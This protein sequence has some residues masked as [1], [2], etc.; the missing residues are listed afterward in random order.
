[1]GSSSIVLEANNITKYY[2]EGLDNTLK[3]LENSSF[4]IKKNEVVA[5]V[6]VSGCGKS[7]LLQICGLLDSQN[8]GEIIIN[9]IDTTKLNDR[10]KTNIRKNNIGFIYQMH[11]L[12]SEFS[13]VENVM[14]PL[15]IDSKESKKKIREKAVQLLEELGL[16]DRINFVPNQLSGGEK[17]RVAIA[18]A[19]ITNPDIILAD[20]P[21][22]N[23]DPENSI[24]IMEILYNIVKK[25]NSSLFMVTHNIALTQYSDRILTIKDLKVQ[26]ISK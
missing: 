23:L 6:G 14:L 5:F 10:E 26:E 11:Y 9:N 1:M 4:S 12:F 13:V 19:L 17:Q 24:K 3:I 22:G 25:R 16:E 18:R 21:T 7:T 8:F 15:L 20:E 2:K